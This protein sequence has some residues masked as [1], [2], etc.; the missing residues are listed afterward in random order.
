MQMPVSIYSHHSA[1]L[2]AA[3]WMASAALAGKASSGHSSEDVPT[4]TTDKPPK[5]SGA[6]SHAAGQHEVVGLAILPM[7]IP[8]DPPSCHPT[9][10]STSKSAQT[11]ASSRSA[12]QHSSSNALQSGPPTNNSVVGD[13]GLWVLP[14]ALLQDQEKNLALE[15]DSRPPADQCRALLEYVFTSNS[16][17]VCFDM[18]GE[19]HHFSWSLDWR[20]CTHV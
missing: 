7:A 17:T 10:A 14:L 18:Q 1:P 13:Q 4:A 3:E 8:Q 16:S 11:T 5:D 15:D 19:P 9:P 12:M 20:S 2:R 6:L